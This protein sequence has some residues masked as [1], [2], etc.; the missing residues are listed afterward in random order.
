MFAFSSPVKAI[1]QAVSSKEPAIA[2]ELIDALDRKLLSRDERHLIREISAELMLNPSENFWALAV[3]PSMAVP[4]QCRLSQPG[5]SVLE[6]VVPPKC[7][8]PVGKKMTLNQLGD[9][10]WHP[11][12]AHVRDHTAFQ[13]LPTLTSQHLHCPSS[14]LT[15]QPLKFRQKFSML[16]PLVPHPD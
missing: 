1:Q 15:I 7:P 2:L 5:V 4:P 14:I 9:V 13:M 16:T 6:A 10:S 12:S 3:A 8:P 11:C